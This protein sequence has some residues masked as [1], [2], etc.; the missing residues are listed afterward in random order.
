MKLKDIFVV[1]ILL[2]GL[3]ECK[4]S[5]T[6]NPV[7]GSNQTLSLIGTKWVLYQYKDQTM[8]NPLSRHDTLVFT[9]N[10][11]YKWNFNTGV[12][13]LIDNGSNIVHLSLYNT[14]F[15]DIS[16]IVPSNFVTNKEIVG[17]SFSQ[18][19]AGNSQTYNMWFLQI[20]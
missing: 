20:N 4:K 6:S 1:F 9:D 5:T 19:I 13:S 12:Y 2:F 10:T 14:S 16:G 8:N 15:G 7:F 11:S 17:A 3:T 18:L